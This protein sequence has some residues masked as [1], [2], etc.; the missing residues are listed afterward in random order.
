MVQRRG[1]KDAVFE[2]SSPIHHA[3]E[4]YN[5]LKDKIED[6]HI[7]FV[8]ADGGPDHRLTYLSVQLSLIALV[9]NLDLDMLIAGRTAPAHSWANP[10]ERPSLILGFSA[11]GS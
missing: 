6:R 4:L 9:R 10:V 7:L 3:T 1:V 5:Y 2:P 8:Y 11:L